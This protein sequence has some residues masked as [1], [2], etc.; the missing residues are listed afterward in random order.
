MIAHFFS[1][2]TFSNSLPS[3]NQ[4][5]CGGLT[6]SG[7]NFTSTIG[8]PVYNW[9]NS[10][11]SIGLPAS[12]SGNIAAFIATNNAAAPVT[13]S[14]IVTPSVSNC[15]GMPDTFLVTVN[16]RPSVPL[17]TSPVTYCQNATPAILTATVSGTD[18]L[19]WYN[20]A[21]LT[22]GTL[23]APTPVTSAPGT[24]LY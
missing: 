3:A 16:P 8:T 7:Y 18:T 15:I 23:T 6:T 13:A 5:L 4:T 19:T 11:P 24:T 12:G 9:T 2:H 10:N 1:N 22:G 21:A 17:V 20:N 14:I